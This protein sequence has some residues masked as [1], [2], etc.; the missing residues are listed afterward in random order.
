MMTLQM[1]KTT[2]A[3]VEDA[4]KLRKHWVDEFNKHDDFEV[5]FE[6]DDEIGL[7]EYLDNGA[8][9]DFL[10]LDLRLHDK[11]AGLEI[12]EWI[13][14]KEVDIKVVVCSNYTDEDI[15]VGTLD[16]GAKAFVLKGAPSDITKAIRIIQQEGIFITDYMLDALR[17]VNSK[18][19]T[20][21]DDLQLRV[22]ESSNASTTGVLPPLSS[23]QLRILKLFCTEL[24][25]KEI[26]ARE[27]I[28]EKEVE[29]FRERLC[30]LFGA[31]NRYD[32]V[33]KAAKL[34]V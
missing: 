3:C 8:H 25:Y 18:L 16:L 7:Y 13:R 24:T 19:R 11:L 5:I 4:P 32:L 23:D 31:V 33:Y 14:A 20:R 21:L 17:K 9:P 30:V 15:M 26:A 27:K 2:I 6:A 28:T 22:S 1:E 10:V 12:L 34:G 29:R